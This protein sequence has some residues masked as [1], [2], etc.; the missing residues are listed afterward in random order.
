[1]NEAPGAGQLVGVRQRQYFVEEVVPKGPGDDSTLVRLSCL[2]DDAQGQ[3]LEVLWDKEIDSEIIKG[4]A[5][6]TIASR[7]F[8]PPKLLSAYLH[9]LPW[10]CVTS[11]DPNLFQSPFRAGI[12]IDAYQLD[13]LQRPGLCPAR[14]RESTRVPVPARC[15]L[16]RLPIDRRNLLRTAQ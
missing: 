14:A 5:W 13:L 11:T 15:G 2:D 4:E 9:T 12:R 16:P 3:P 6:Q 10:N 1:M 8:D 7:G